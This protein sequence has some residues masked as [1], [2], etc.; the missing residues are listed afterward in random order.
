MIIEG[1]RR[2]DSSDLQEKAYE[3]AKVWIRVNYNTFNRTGVMWEKYSVDGQ[4]GSGGEYVV[5]AGFG[6]TNGVM[7]DL[8]TT[9]AKRLDFNDIQATNQNISVTDYSASR[10][11]KRFAR[12]A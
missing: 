11:V 10:R 12:N 8:M 4:I 9:Y 7:L 6:W 2:S 1:F 5:Q 3:L